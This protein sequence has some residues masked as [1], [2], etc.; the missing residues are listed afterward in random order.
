MSNNTSHDDALLATLREALARAEQDQ[1]QSE[2]H[3]ATIKADLAESVAKLRAEADARIEA[4]KEGTAAVRRYRAAIA[5]ITGEKAERPRATSGRAPRRSYDLAEV[6][7]VAREAVAAGRPFSKA[8]M[9]HFDVPS[10]QAT[11]LLNQARAAGHDAPRGV[12]SRQ[13]RKL[14]A[15]PSRP[16]HQEPH[17][18]RRMEPVA[19]PSSYRDVPAGHFECDD[20]DEHFSSIPALTRHVIT[21]HDRRTLSSTERTPVAA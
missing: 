17:S 21:A 18:P 20:C 8:V 9:E 7:R 14:D 15:E 5:A 6:A 12:N 19:K 16:A 13:P 1:A 4:A 11:G 2:A 3:I 10:P